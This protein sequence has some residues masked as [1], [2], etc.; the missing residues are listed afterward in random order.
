MCFLHLVA[1]FGWCLTVR[2][3]DVSSTFLQGKENTGEPLHMFPPSQGLPGIEAGLILRLQKAVYGRPD[4]PRT[5]FDMFSGVL[6]NDFGFERSWL[7][8]DKGCPIAMI[9]MHVDDILL[10]TNSSIAV[11]EKINLLQKR[12]P[13]GEWSLAHEK[14]EGVIYCSNR[15]RAIMESGD[16]VILL[17]QEHFVLCRLEKIELSKSRAS[18]L[19]S[20]P[21]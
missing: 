9:V 10:A 13:F 19:D 21:P 4:A 11:K 3:G 8:P 5:W 18:E 17:G 14:T 1:S 12:F 20:P 16:Y 7:D 15:I 6:V 2:S